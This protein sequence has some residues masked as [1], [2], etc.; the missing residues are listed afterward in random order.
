MMPETD[1][2]TDLTKDHRRLE[3]DIAARRYF[4]KFGRIVPLLGSVAGEMVRDRRL[5]QIDSDIVG[6]YAT[7]IAATFRA[8]SLKY[9]MAGRVEGLSSQHLTIDF[10]ESGFPVFQE[11]LTM[12]SD[13]QYAEA[14]LRDMPPAAQMRD[15]MIRQIVGDLTIPT[16]LQ[17]AMS[18]RLYNEALV[19]GGLFW[20]KSPPQVLTLGD[21]SNGRRAHL[22]HWAIYDS[23]ANLPVIYLLEVEDSARRPLPK[24]ENRWPAVQAHLLAQS[25]GGLK[26]V[27]I[28][29]GFDKDFDDLHPKRLRRITLGPMYSS[30]FTL[31]TGPIRE[32]LEEAKSPPGDDW[33]LVWTVELLESEKTVREKSGWFGEVDREVYRLD[34][35]SGRGVDT[36]AT[37]LERSIILP[38][39]PYQVLAEKNPEGFRQVRRY[40]VGKDGRVMVQG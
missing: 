2:K 13:A 6:T 3:D 11:L 20:A 31:Q 37:S 18:Q 26:L 30:A 17:Y 1:V 19:A 27:T 8:L 23:V 36:G 38:A 16:R 33:A 10:H 9:L 40:V 39:Q 34:P 14:A 32:V 7:A 12:A 28:A 4:A 29:T 5:S 25:V 22:I 21:L 24:D 35:Y 15:E